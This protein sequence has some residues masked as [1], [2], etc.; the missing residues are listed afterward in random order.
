MAHG[1]R[2]S[3]ALP[4]PPPLPA[5]APGS[6]AACAWPVAGGLRIRDLEGAGA[7]VGHLQLQ[8]LLTGCRAAQRAGLH[9]RPPQPLAVLQ[10]PRPQRRRPA[11]RR[12]LLG[13]LLLEQQGARHCRQRRQRRGGRRH[14][15]QLMGMP[16]D[17][18][19]VKLAGLEG[20]V[21]GQAAQEADVRGEAR[22]LRGRA[23]N[24]V[25]VKVS[26]GRGCAGWTMRHRG[27]WLWNGCER[28]GVLRVCVEGEAAPECSCSE[29]KQRGKPHRRRR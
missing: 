21:G 26:L 28:A 7:Q 15:Q 29:S 27:G 23:T 20:R 1:D 12:L 19:G 14:V 24:V 10:P 13:L 16:A 22:H 3:C 9:E 25:C 5:V 18:A 17:E 11:A 2:R 4:L 6:V 8:L